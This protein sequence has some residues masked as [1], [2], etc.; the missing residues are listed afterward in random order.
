MIIVDFRIDFQRHIERGI[1]MLRSIFHVFLIFVLCITASGIPVRADVFGS[2]SFPHISVQQKS[3]YHFHIEKT[4]LKNPSEIVLQIK[5]N[6]FELDPDSLV[7]TLQ[8]DIIQDGRTLSTWE[9]SDFIKGILQ[10]PDEQS[11]IL[12]LAINLE[13]ENFDLP[14]GNYTFRIYSTE[15]KLKNTS[16][17]SLNIEYAP[18]SQY[19]AAAEKEPR[20][21]TGMTL[22]FPDPSGQYFI[23]IS[24]FVPYTRIP[25]RT[26]IDNLREGSDELGLTCEIPE[27]ERL[28]VRRDMV[29]VHLP[30]DLGE[31][32]KDAVK[33]TNALNSL[34]SSLTSLPG[35]N[36]VKFLLDGKE[37]DQI[38][39]HYRTDM[40]FEHDKE[41]KIYL[42][43]DHDQK[44][45]LL[46]PHSFTVSDD[47]QRIPEMFSALKTA[48]IQ[49]QKLQPLIAPIPEDVV[50][51]NF[52]QRGNTLT[53]NLNKEFL[54]VYP[55]RPDLQRW[56]IDSMIYSFTSI[57]GIDQVQILIENQKIS[58]LNGIPLSKPLKRPQFINP[59][60]E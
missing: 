57:D 43:I 32:N 39:H 23:P 12:T 38:F 24:R 28:Q 7:S 54:S 1:P 10:S 36:R 49:D 35:I 13:Q 52:A 27:V 48:T 6:D 17:L 40:I 53:L 4:D 18:L 25:I 59:E 5:S 51:H 44:R 33:G 58:D 46:V 41:P 56:M 21:M 34:V 20:G 11:Q 37:S 15:K 29:I 9:D 19:I 14:N 60:K 47:A 22:Y 2:I 31:Y 16:P 8:L 55:D 30:S 42:G 45:L 3:E 26:T 50:L